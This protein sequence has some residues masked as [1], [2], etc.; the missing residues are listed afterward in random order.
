M[1]RHA[2]HFSGTLK[3]IYHCGFGER[4]RERERER[5]KGERE[6]EKSIGEAQEQETHK[7][8]RWGTLLQRQPDCFE[9]ATYIG[10]PIHR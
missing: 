6:R 9:T 4:E 10:R 3:I 2:D 8:E 7:V 5:E 1:H